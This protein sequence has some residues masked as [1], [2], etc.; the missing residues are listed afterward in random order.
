MVKRMEGFRVRHV[1]DTRERRLLL[2]LPLSSDSVASSI[3]LVYVLDE[4]LRVQK[5]RTGRTGYHLHVL[6]LISDDTKSEDEQ[7]C[8]SFHEELKKKVQDH[9]ISI[10]SLEDVLSTEPFKDGVKRFAVNRYSTGN[11]SHTTRVDLRLLLERLAIVQLARKYGSECVL[12]PHSTTELA[13]LILSETAKGNGAF[14]GQLIADGSSPYLAL[15]FQYPMRDLL[16]K[17]IELFMNMIYPEGDF[18]NAKRKRQEVVKN[19]ADITI[20]KVMLNYCA[21]TEKS[22]PN[23]VANVVRTC[24]KLEVAADLTYSVRCTLCTALTRT[25]SYKF[26]RDSSDSLNGASNSD[27]VDLCCGCAK[28]ISDASGDIQPSSR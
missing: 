19:A 7:Y 9:Q 10:E 24:A 23:I 27:L 20:D 6:L 11:L 8:Q 28:I 4:H 17:E 25:D 21:S 16:D 1:S 22:Y 3:A 12:W 5:E 15:S 14:V 18:V 26:L 2:P 13:R